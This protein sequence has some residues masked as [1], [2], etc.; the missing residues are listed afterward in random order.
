MDFKM[1]RQ[2]SVVEKFFPQQDMLKILW[3]IHLFD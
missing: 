1:Q 2:K 3:K